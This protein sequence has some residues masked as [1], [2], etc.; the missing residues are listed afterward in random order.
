M[1]T[2]P[3]PQPDIDAAVDND[4]LIKAAILDL[5]DS[6]VTDRAGVLGQ[7]RFVVAK[8]VER[9]PLRGRRG[10]AIERTDALL[11]RCVSLEPSEDE[12][13][14]AAVIERTAALRDLPLD[15]GESQLAAI[16]LS[17][18]I[19]ELHTGDKRAIAAFEMRVMT[20]LGPTAMA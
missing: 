17:R 16:V 2:V 3:E 10:A 8:R 7:A 12:I 14:L 13:A 15:A 1:S 5:S 18:P 9:M 6:L 20:S 4:I 11:A 19:A